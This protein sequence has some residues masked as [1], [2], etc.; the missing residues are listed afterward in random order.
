MVFDWSQAGIVKKV[1][2]FFLIFSDCPFYLLLLEIAGFFGDTFFVLSSLVFL[3]CQ[4]PQ[5]PVWAI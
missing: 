2:F 3:G 4:L 1:F 5:Y